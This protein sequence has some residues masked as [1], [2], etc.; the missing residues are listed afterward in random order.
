MH[1]DMREFSKFESVIGK[2]NMPKT[3]AMFQ[4]MKYNKTEEYKMFKH[5]R[6]A[7]GNG[8]ISALASFTLFKSTKTRIENL[9]LGQTA[10]NGTVIQS[11]SLH[12]VDRLIGSIYENPK[13]EGMSLKDM[14]NILLNGVP[15]RTIKYNK[16]NKPSQNIEIENLGIVTINPDTG[17]LI[18]CNKS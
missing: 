6:F 10:A 12:F 14:Q 13:H 3:L 5:Y 18:Q 7:R 11:V 9:T 8:K 2:D 15:K 1:R 16:D 4:E 17:E